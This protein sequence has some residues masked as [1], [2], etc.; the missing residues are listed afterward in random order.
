MVENQIDVKV[1]QIKTDNRNEF[2]N[3]KL[4]S[5]CDEK[6]ISQKFSSLY[7][8]EQI[9]VAKKKNRTLIEASRTM[10][11]RVFKTRSQQ[12]EETFHVTFDESIEAIRFTNTSVDEI[13]IDDSSRYLLMNLL[14]KMTHLDS[15]KSILNFHT[16]SFLVDVEGPSDPI[17][18]KGTKEHNVQDE[19]INHQ[20]TEETSG[21]NT[22]TLVH[23][24]KLL[25]LEAAQSQDTNHALTSSYHVVQDRW[26][27]DQHIK[28]VNIIGDPGKGMLTRSMVA[29]LIA[30]SASECLFADFL[31]EIELKKVS[32]A[33]KHLGRV[34]AMQEELNHFYKNKVWTLV[35]LT[36]G[37]IAIGSKFTNKKDEH[38]IVTKSKARLV[39]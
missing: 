28:L 5:F 1:K 14:K 11:N 39:A 8:P 18:T 35:P 25:V 19:E 9:G 23:I 31:F 7:T 6:G 15:I 12:I 32:K 20:P 37:K 10:L 13:R 26:S 16:T 36:H 3:F 30:T 34:D 33:L 24:T 4:E 21:N 27:R 29:K 38:G 22:K 17:N 2:K